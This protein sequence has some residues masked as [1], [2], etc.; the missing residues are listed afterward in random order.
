MGTTKRKK[1][2]CPGGTI[3]KVIDFISKTDQEK[4]KLAKA[5]LYPI[6]RFIN[7]GLKYVSDKRMQ[8]LRWFAKLSVAL[9]TSTSTSSISLE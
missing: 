2:D 4:I 5:F 9:A 7:I 3:G 1:D 8:S 6:L